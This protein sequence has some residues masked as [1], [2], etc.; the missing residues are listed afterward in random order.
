MEMGKLLV[1]NTN[2]YNTNS[3]STN[4]LTS[5]TQSAGSDDDV[6]N[7][8]YVNNTNELNRP[9][10]RYHIDGMDSQLD[11]DTAIQMGHI[12]FWMTGCMSVA[13][14]FG[15]VVI[16]VTYVVF[17]DLRTSGRK[18]LVYLSIADFFTAQGNLLGIS[19]YIMKDVIS[20]VNSENLCK[21]HAVLTICS[22]ISSF[23]W[24]VVIATHLY[25]CIVKGQKRLAR[26]LLPYFHVVCWFI[27][28]KISFLFISTMLLLLN[29]FTT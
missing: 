4:T 10:I 9:T 27:P 18:L 26:T 17:P 8:L 7:S 22:S 6:L 24:T 29:H 15:S 13:S 1:K 28:G 23:L 16:I 21:F 20:P 14:M 5:A 25:L 12:Y 2:L 3:T 19:W 11:T